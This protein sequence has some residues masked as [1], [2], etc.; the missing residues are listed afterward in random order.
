MSFGCRVG[1]TVGNGWPRG[2]K[3]VERL[4]TP[5][6]QFVIRA[7]NPQL[8]HAPALAALLFEPRDQKLGEAVEKLLATLPF[9]IV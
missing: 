9:Q 7:A 3:G 6:G 4:P 8:E 2:G 1:R 5:C